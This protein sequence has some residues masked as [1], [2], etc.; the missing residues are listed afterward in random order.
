MHV[1]WSLLCDATVNCTWAPFLY[2]KNDVAHGL[3]IS[4]ITH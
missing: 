2:L 3:S 4:K 1:P